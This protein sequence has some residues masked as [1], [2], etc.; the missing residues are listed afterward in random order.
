M[1]K[2]SKPKLWVVGDSFAI[3]PGALGDTP[4]QKEK[5]HPMG[6]EVW[7]NRLG[8]LLGCESVVNN[9]V[10]GS[11]QDWIGYCLHDWKNLI[12]P[13]DYV[14]CVL[15]HPGRFWYFHDHPDITNVNILD[16]DNHISKDQAKAIELY[17][18]HI[19]RPQLDTQWLTQRLG[20]IAYMFQQKKLRKPLMVQA[21]PMDLDEAVT[22]PDIHFAK[23]NLFMDV[24]YPEFEPHDEH[25]TDHTRKFW[26]GVDC[27]YNHMC[28]RNHEVLAQ[29]I[30]SWFEGT[31]EEVD[32]TVG[33]HHGFLA[34]SLLDDPE[35]CKAELDPVQLEKNQEIQNREYMKNKNMLPWHK[36]V[37]INIRNQ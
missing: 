22:Y 20:W 1:T 24:Q 10:I 14:V 23:G 6:D 29:K 7:T 8:Q 18:K 12:A 35:F 19:Q 32:L 9:S 28:L 36:R 33:F 26:S 34:K 15:T 17:I 11:S 13:E 16:L 31:A 30:S 37:G 5:D 2:T 21:F 3:P 27:R 25:H 4:E